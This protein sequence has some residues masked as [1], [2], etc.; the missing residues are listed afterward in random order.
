MSEYND[1]GQTEQEPDTEVSVDVSPLLAEFLKQQKA[2][3]TEEI[4]TANALLS[5]LTAEQ[6]VMAVMR[7]PSIEIAVPF[8]CKLIDKDLNAANAMIGYLEKKFKN[9][10]TSI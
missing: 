9:E 2:K 7:A 1:L 6:L 5:Q 8:V 10:D 4:A 3:I